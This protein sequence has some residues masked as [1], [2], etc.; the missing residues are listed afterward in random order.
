MHL[1]IRRRTGNR[2][3]L[4]LEASYF[5]ASLCP[6]LLENDLTGSMYELLHEKYDLEP[7]RLHQEVEV[8]Q[9][10]SSYAA[11]MGVRRD[12]M[13]LQVLRTAWH[14]DGRPFEFA[15]DIYR[16]DRLVFTEGTDWFSS[17]TRT[18]L[19]GNTKMSSKHDRG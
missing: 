19:T 10:D 7:V 6:E 13:V 18:K 12:V 1:L 8:T 14:A 11:K 5:P 17:P 4:A 16:G 9:L 3:P 15:R 2:E